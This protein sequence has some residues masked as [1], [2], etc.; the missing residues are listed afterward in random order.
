MEVYDAVRTVLA[1]RQYQSKPVPAETVRRILEAGRLT[2][3]ASNRQPWHFILVDDKETIGKLAALATTGPYIAQAPMVI[4]VAVEN[5]R[6]GLSDGSRAIQS[7]VLTAWSE[8]IG[9]NWV[10]FA[11]MDQIKPLLNIPDTLDVIAILPMG[12]PAKKLGYGKKNRKSVA[13]VIHHGRF[14]QPYTG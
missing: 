14:G 3:S 9:S 12:Y 11:G 5:N 4:V 1:V 6:F 8:G 10:G 13:E 2:A 7:M